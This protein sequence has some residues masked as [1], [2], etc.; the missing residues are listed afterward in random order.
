MKKIYYK[1]IVLLNLLIVDTIYWI[2]F[3][4]QCLKNIS[5]L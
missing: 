3:I 4:E 5:Y 1:D 2:R